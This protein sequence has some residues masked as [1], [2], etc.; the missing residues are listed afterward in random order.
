MSDGSPLNS[1]KV[2]TETSAIRSAMISTRRLAIVCPSPALD[3]R[4]QPESSWIDRLWTRTRYRMRLRG[5]RLV[6]RYPALGQI[7]PRLVELRMNLRLRWLK[8]RVRR[9][10][11]RA[12][13]LENS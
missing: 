6:F 7:V 1:D 4:G 5:V 3:G 9:H 11:K 2:R 12:S 13:Q 8:L 10:L